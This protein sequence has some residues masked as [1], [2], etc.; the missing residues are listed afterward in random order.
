MKSDSDR[1]GEL[2]AV[3]ADALR[4]VESRLSIPRDTFRTFPVGD[5]GVVFQS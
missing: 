2:D 4:D 5:T 1:R 3:T